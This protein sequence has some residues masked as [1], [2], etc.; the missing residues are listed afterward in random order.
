MAGRM[1]NRR[2]FTLIE[3]MIVVAIVGILGSVALPSYGRYVFRARQTEAHTML[4]TIQKSEFVHLAHNDCYAAVAVAPAAGQLGP[5]PR[6]WDAVAS[7]VTERCPGWPAAPTEKSFTDISVVPKISHVYFEY[8]CSA[9]YDASGDEDN[10]ACCAEGDLDGDN[11]H[12]ELVYGTDEDGD[13]ATLATCSNGTVSNFPMD[14]VRV[15][16]GIF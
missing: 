11:N 2:G 5:V 13:G 12:F 7:G 15:S 9:S 16:P 3:L 1:I 6:S 10:F 8:R 4:S 14:A